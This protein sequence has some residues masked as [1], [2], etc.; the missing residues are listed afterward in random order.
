MSTSSIAPS[1]GHR[2]AIRHLRNSVTVQDQTL[3]V[4]IKAGQIG[5]GSAS[6]NPR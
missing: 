1:I 6:G 4:S 3:A 5:I 2:R